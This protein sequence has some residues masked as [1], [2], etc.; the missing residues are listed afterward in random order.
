MKD[1]SLKDNYYCYKDSFVL[2]NK[3]DI[4]DKKILDLVEKIITESNIL[5]LQSKNFDKKELNYDFFMW[6]HK[7]IF[8]DIYSWAGKLR[9]VD[10]TKGEFKFAHYSYLDN[11]MSDYFESLKEENYLIDYENDE[12]IEKLTYYITELNIIHPFREGN[13]RVIREYFRILLKRKN[14]YIDYSNKEKYLEGMIESPYKTDKLK[15]FL[16]DNLKNIEQ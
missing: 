10:L 7:Y 2:K 8:G 3:L 11:L 13:G 6:L 15:E 12:L 14:L 9:V 16:N 5:L 1:Y 4:K